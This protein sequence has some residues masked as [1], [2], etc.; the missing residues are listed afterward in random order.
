MSSSRRDSPSWIRFR[1]PSMFI[2]V[3]VNEYIPGCRRFSKSRRCGPSMSLVT[4]A[5]VA[6]TRSY[7]RSA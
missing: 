4:G 5:A 6:M 2:D 1:Y 7:S 3:H